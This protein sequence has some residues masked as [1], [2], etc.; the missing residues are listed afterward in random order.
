[1]SSG[2]SAS[3][4]FSII[5]EF[6]KDALLALPKCVSPERVAGSSSCSVYFLICSW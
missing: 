5:A 1:M 3:Q 2:I 4:F 6:L